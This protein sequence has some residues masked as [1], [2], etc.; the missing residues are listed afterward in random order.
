MPLPFDATLKSIVA[1]RPDDF[2]PVFGLPTGER[3]A[4]VNVDLSTISAATDV[5][6]AYGQPIH[7]IVDLNFQSGPDA[8][9][10]GRLLLYNA[11]LNHRHGVAVR[12][13]LVLLRKSAD[14][15]HLTGLHAYGS[16]PN[17]V[18]FHYEVVRLWQHPVD[19]LLKL[20]PAALPFATLGELPLDRSKVDALREIVLEM[21]RRLGN[22]TDPAESARLLTAA[23]TLTA[24]RTS[25]SELSSIYRGVG[26]VN[27]PTAWDEAVEAGELRGEL[28][29]EIQRSH[30]LLLRLGSKQ[31]GTP[32]E[33]VEKELKSIQNLDRLE[34][35][36]DAILSAKS[37]QELLA[38]T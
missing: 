5:A 37:W 36:A 13:I 29:G 23:Y 6:L 14:G 21:I 10:P 2:A 35:L 33:G 9:L 12:S 15:T 28:R 16:R 3:V 34:R 31:L 25:I 17:R 26:I 4:P 1:E 38:T 18:E 7:S 30:R 11:A 19:A 22:E 27:A 24:L 20:N 32:D 8:K